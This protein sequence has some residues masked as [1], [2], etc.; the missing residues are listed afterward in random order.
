MTLDLSA[1][2]YMYI[3]KK[4]YCHETTV[5]GCRD[6]ILSRHSSSFAPHINF[7]TKQSEPECDL[8]LLELDCKRTKNKNQSMFIFQNKQILHLNADIYP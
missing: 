4:P 8:T 2:E 6:C 1:Y 5:E 3:S 7:L